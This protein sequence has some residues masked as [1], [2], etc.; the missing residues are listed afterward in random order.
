MN[1][2]LVLDRLRIISLSVSNRK[3]F[4]LKLKEILFNPDKKDGVYC[5]LSIFVDEVKIDCDLYLIYEGISGKDYSYLL[6]L[7]YSIENF[8]KENS[9]LQEISKKLAFDFKSKIDISFWNEYLIKQIF[10]VNI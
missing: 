4:N 1:D 8:L 9:K 5:S 2:L 7:K 3:K 6:S 10:Y